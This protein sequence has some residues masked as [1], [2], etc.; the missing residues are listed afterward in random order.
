MEPKDNN[1]ILRSSSCG[2]EVRSQ[3]SCLHIVVGKKMNHLTRRRGQGDKTKKEE[4]DRQNY[5]LQ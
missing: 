3:S 1:F 5:P 4:K 2:Y